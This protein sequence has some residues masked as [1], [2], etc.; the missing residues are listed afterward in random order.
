MAIVATYDKLQMGSD[1][2]TVGDAVF[3]TD[4][5][6]GLIVLSLGTSE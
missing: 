3:V 5:P 6:R 1:I 4:E 2:Q